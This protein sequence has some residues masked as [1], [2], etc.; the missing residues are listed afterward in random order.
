MHVH[1]VFV[2]DSQ[3][4]WGFPIQQEHGLRGTDSC[5][6]NVFISDCLKFIQS[7]APMEKAEMEEFLVHKTT[8]VRR[9]HAVGDEYEMIAALMKFSDGAFKT[10]DDPN[11]QV[12][13]DNRCFNC[14]QKLAK[15]AV[16]DLNVVTLS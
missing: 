4:R 3:Y 10:L 15:Q 13:I 11:L 2:W 6:R 7:L 14:C 5:L 1:V 16:S 9:V 12:C 8:G